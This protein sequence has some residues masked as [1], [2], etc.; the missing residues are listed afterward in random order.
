MTSIYIEVLLNCFLLPVLVD[1]N[2]SLD[3]NVTTN[4]G[5]YFLF[6]SIIRQ[7]YRLAL[8]PRI[9]VLHPP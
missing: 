7:V 1:W 9:Q 5:I 4:A 6:P 2:L 8:R 3:S